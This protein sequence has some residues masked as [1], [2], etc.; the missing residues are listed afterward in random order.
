VPS[1]S[2]CTLIFALATT[3]PDESEMVPDRDEVSWASVLLE[4]KVSSAATRMVAG[5]ENKSLFN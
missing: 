5:R 1:A 4:D 2:L 3:A